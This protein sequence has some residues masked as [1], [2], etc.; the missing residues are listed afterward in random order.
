[1]HR[2]R[3]ELEHLQLPLYKTANGETVAWD[4]WGRV[5]GEQ[6]DAPCSER[7]G[8]QLRSPAGT[9]AS[10]CRFLTARKGDVQAARKMCPGGTR[11]KKSQRLHAETQVRGPFGM[12]A[13]RINKLERGL[14]VASAL[15]SAGKGPFRSRGKD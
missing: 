6:G 4:R 3:K 1:M 8:S 7:A 5:C 14:C 10:L 13:G 2:L 12:E 15:I 9:E 11:R